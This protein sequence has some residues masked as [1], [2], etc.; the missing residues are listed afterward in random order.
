MKFT[1][2]K[3]AL[4]ALTL[5][6]IIL[7]Y[8]QLTYAA[9]AS[10]ANIFVYPKPFKIAD[11]V[12]RNPSGQRVSLSDYQGK[13]VLLHFWSIQCPACRMEEPDLHHLKKTFGPQGLEVLGVNLVDSPQAIT[14]YAVANQMPFPV[15][16]D[17]GQGFKLQVVNMAGKNTAFVVTPGREAV[18]EVPGFPTTYILDCR[19]SAVGYSFGAARWNDGAALTLIKSLISEVK[20]CRPRISMNVP[21]TW[22]LW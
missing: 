12:L 6:A 1:F 18:L 19:G 20:T 9:G 3:A 4:L 11:L 17:G 21:G 15:L 22:S 13:V 16:F 8:A 7:A 10:D 5:S 14:G 2:G